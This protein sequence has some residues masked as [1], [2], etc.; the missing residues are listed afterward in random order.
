[1]I[2][3]CKALNCLPEEIENMIPEEDP[4]PL[5]KSIILVYFQY[6]KIIKAMDESSLP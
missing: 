3:S 5:V 2:L 6:F 1:M 4:Y